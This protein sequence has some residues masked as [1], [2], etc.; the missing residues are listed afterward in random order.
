MQ[1]I[2][3][4]THTKLEVTQ[5]PMAH[6]HLLPFLALILLILPSSSHASETPA[7]FSD[8]PQFLSGGHNLTV[9]NTT[10]SLSNDCGLILY[11][12]DAPFIDFKTSTTAS[13]CILQLNR[14]GQLVLT[15]GD[16]TGKTQTI[17]KKG[18]EGDYALLFVGGTLSIYGPATWN[19][20][21]SV[22]SSALKQGML[23]AGTSDVFIVSDQIVNSGVNPSNGNVIAAITENCTFAVTNDITGEKIWETTREYDN[24]EDCYLLLVDGL[25]LLQ[26][27]NGSTLLTQWTGGYPAGLNFYVAV[28][29]YYGRITIY[30]LSNFLG[31]SP[32]SA[33]VAV[34]AAAAAAAGNIKMVTV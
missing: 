27:Y 26:G 25:L 34:A 22:P 21:V 7:L 11:L 18:A 31:V 15:P 1:T 3:L 33:A 28:L 29:R 2:L 23:K 6:H 24:L 10:L 13:Q 19:N 16:E 32:S 4:K 30:G 20:N 14:Y 17:L 12:D 9:G 8:P 5:K